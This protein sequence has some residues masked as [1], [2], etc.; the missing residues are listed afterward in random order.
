MGPK[1]PAGEYVDGKLVTGAPEIP[2]YPWV[3]TYDG[4]VL[5]SPAIDYNFEVTSYRFDAPGTH[6]IE[7]RLGKIASNAISV[8]VR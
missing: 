1:R 3:A 5:P 7:W 2:E 8:R 4:A 6:V